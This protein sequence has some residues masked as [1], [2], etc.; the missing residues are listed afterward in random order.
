MDIDNVT[1]HLI[2][3]ELASVLGHCRTVFLAVDNSGQQRD[4]ALQELMDERREL[5]T[6]RDNLASEH[7]RREMAEAKVTDVQ[8]QVRRLQ[9]SSLATA[10]LADARTRLTEYALEAE[11][12]QD[13]E[14]ATVNTTENLRK[15]IWRVTHGAIS[16]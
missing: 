2:Q 15:K 3:D 16:V 11:Y 7:G 6:L 8:A 5:K 1:L 14:A 10:E 12:F 9:A 13:R 4:T